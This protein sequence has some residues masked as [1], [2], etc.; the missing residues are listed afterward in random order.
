MDF[1][2]VKIKIGDFTI[3]KSYGGDPKNVGIYC[4]SGEGGDFDAELL[5]AALEKAL[6]EFYKE[7]F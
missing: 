7:H 3:C 5:K 4:S 6:I 2:Q 1:V